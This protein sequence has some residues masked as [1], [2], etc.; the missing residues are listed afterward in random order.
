MPELL[1]TLFFFLIA[2]I[3]LIAVHEFGHYWVARRLGVRVLRFSLGF[4]TVIWRHQKTPMDTEF[5]LSALPLGG[6]VRMVDEREAPVAEADLPYAFNRKPLSVRSAVVLAGP[7]FNFLLAIL[8]YWVT[9]MWGETGTRPVVGEV[10]Q[11]T[12]AGFAGFQEDDEILE[13]DDTPTPTWVLAVGGIMERLLDEEPIPVKVKTAAGEVRDLS[14]VKPQDVGN[15]PEAVY[16]RLGLKPKEPSLEPVIERIVAG[17]A[18]EQAGLKAGDRILKADDQIIKTW[19]AWVDYVRVRPGQVIE[20]VIERNDVAVDLQLTPAAVDSAEG[21]I[22]QI[23]AAVKVPEDLKKSMEVD[24]RL[25]PWSAL[26]AAI[27][28]TGTYSFATLKMAG[29]MLIGKAAVENLSGPISIAQYAGQSA[30]LGMIQFLKFLALVSISLGVLNLL[31]IPVLDGGHLLFYGAEAIMG[32]PLHEKTQIRFQQ[33]GMAILLLLM[34]L[35]FYLD[36]GRL[37]AS[38]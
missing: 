33:M 30:S 17:S 22:G 18:A 7:L 2:L 26:V 10:V 16:Q 15:Q 19:K 36:I 24:Y 31:P 5:T 12:I 21:T 25:G 27:K 23:G 20:A 38:N 11:G 28:R 13:V 37:F 35:G 6:Y 9:L 3:V 29:R 14:V 34:V 1:H 4:G 8:I 32:R